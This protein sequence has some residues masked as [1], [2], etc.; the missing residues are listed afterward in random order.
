MPERHDERVKRSEQ[1]GMAY[2]RLAKELRPGYVFT[3][4]PGVYFIPALIDQWKKEKKFLDF[5]NFD[6]VEKYLDF[7]GVR[8]E[9]NVL[10]TEGGHRVLGRPIPKKTQDVEEAIRG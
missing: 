3:V 5:V 1:F 10:V 9:D 6:L 7:G 8:I 2:L 4:E